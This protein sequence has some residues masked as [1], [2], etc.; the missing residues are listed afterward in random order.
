MSTIPLPA[1]PGAEE[2]VSL[3]LVNSAVQ[4][5]GDK[6]ADELGSP[7]QATGWLIDRGLVP[8]DTALL[9]YCQNQ[10]TGLRRDLRAVFEAQTSG[11][12]PHQAAVDAINRALT[13][14]PSAQLL[15]YAP[16]TGFHRVME[17]PVTQLVEHAMAIIA[18]D[19]ATLLS[20]ERPGLLARCGAAP[21]D[22]FLI[23][24]HARRHWCST[25]C[26]DRVRAARAYARKQGKPQEDASGE[27]AGRR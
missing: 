4:L 15:R 25:R 1:A 17:D 22:R 19:A 24:T 13:R 23:R 7:E 18:E 27:D 16:D 8:A 20:S 5:P 12:P 11:A 21:C 26:G 10:L 9:S 2:H 14:A 6:R 3:A